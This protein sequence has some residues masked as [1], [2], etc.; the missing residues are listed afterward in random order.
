MTWFR[1]ATDQYVSQCWSW[2]LSSYGSPSSN[3]LEIIRRAYKRYHLNAFF[4]IMSY[5][6]TL[7]YL[8]QQ[9]ILEQKSA[10]ISVH[11]LG[12]RH[13][14]ICPSPN[15]IVYLFPHT[16]R[17]F[18]FRL[19]DRN[20]LVPS[21][22][23]RLKFAISTTLRGDWSRVDPYHKSHNASDKYPTVHHF[24]REMCTFLLQKWCIVGYGTGALCDL[25]NRYIGIG[26]RESDRSDS[27]GYERPW[28]WCV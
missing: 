3:E 16:H 15:S 6:L 2:L 8:N 18:Y 23:S 26:A 1:Q 22:I 20:I 4:I 12:L 17:I 9:R 25:W 13:S 5:C 11:C 14:A 28:L 10:F 27:R 21:N 7:F 24:V 19:G